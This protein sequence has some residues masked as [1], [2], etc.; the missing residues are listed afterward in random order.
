VGLP[1]LFDTGFAA[2]LQGLA[3]SEAARMLLLLDPYYN[4]SKVRKRTAE[5]KRAAKAAD[6]AAAAAARDRLSRFKRLTLARAGA[7][8]AAGGQ[9]GPA[10]G[11]HRQQQPSRSAPAGMQGIQQELLAA[12]VFS[13]HDLQDATGSLGDLGGD[14]RGGAQQV[15]RRAAQQRQTAVQVAQEWLRAQ[16][17]LVLVDADDDED[18]DDDMP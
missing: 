16:S 5:E 4:A 9:H 13:E 14:L 8:G 3:N 15:L 10:A 17:A 2:S 1:E 11:H 12:G 6:E 18:G 7:D